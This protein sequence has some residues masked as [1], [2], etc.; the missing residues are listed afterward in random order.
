[1]LRRTGRGKDNIDAGLES[2]RERGPR[3]CLDTF[4][5][6][7]LGWFIG[8]FLSWKGIPVVDGTSGTDK[9]GVLKAALKSLAA[10]LVIGGFLMIG[11]AQAQTDTTP[12]L[13]WG[14]EAGLT[15][16]KLSGSVESGE[17]KKIHPGFRIGGFL[18]YPVQEMF[19]LDAGLLFN[20]KGVKVEN[21]PIDETTAK[22][23]ENLNYLSIPVLAKVKF[24]AGSS[25][26]PYIFAGP[27]LG[28]LLQAKDKTE[29][30]GGGST[31]V[32]VKDSIKST[33]FGIDLGAG[34]EFP[35]S[36]MTGRIEGGYD[37]GLTD[38]AKNP[39]P[40]AESVKTQT[41]HFEVGI[42]F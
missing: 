17:S 31:E 5:A 3:S 2:S 8:T 21:V 13:S 4:V 27:Q 25:A 15:L 9:E 14:G 7:F 40:G 37:L 16:G 11:V 23:T 39:L 22:V 18:E 32:D 26:A 1:L 30:T 33:E 28:I 12:K 24:A 35:L 34:L 19:A 20:V 29:P 6:T 42:K 10:V 41:I 36:D 38:I